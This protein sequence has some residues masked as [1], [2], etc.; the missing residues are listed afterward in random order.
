MPVSFQ[1]MNIYLISGENTWSLG[2][3]FTFFLSLREAQLL[4]IFNV[5]LKISPWEIINVCGDNRGNLSLL[6]NS[7]ILEHSQI[8]K[9]HALNPEIKSIPLQPATIFYQRENPPLYFYRVT[10]LGASF[11]LGRLI[12]YKQDTDITR[13]QKGINRF[14]PMRKW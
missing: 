11:D 2:S 12:L 14:M 6:W 4:G 8:S 13:R 1:M 3:I 9:I 10:W 5:I 7:I